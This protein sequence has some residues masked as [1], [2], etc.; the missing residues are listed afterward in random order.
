M[1]ASASTG[2]VLVDIYRPNQGWIIRRRIKFIA[3]KS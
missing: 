3:D 1:V 2:N